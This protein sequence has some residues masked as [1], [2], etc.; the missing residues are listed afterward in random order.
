M[1]LESQ[2][3]IARM[4]VSDGGKAWKRNEAGTD[5]KNSVD[6]KIMYS[7]TEKGST[8]NGSEYRVGGKFL[9]KLKLKRNLPER[10]AG[11]I[12]GLTNMDDCANNTITI[13]G[14][15]VKGGGM[16]ITL[17][18]QAV[19]GGVT[20]IKKGKGRITI[21]EMGDFVGT[22]DNLGLDYSDSPPNSG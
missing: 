19:E 2:D 6:D 9:I 8:S 1:P 15:S 13:R 4:E 10:F 11:N 22:V 5:K 3:Q 20:I 14:S 12:D 17:D 7:K 18:K 16:I 21:N